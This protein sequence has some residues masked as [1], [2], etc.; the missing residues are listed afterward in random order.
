MIDLETRRW[1]ARISFPEPPDENGDD[2]AW[3]SWV[4]AFLERFIQAWFTLELHPNDDDTR[5]V[6]LAC[7]RKTAPPLLEAAQQAVLRVHEPW[8]F[9][10]PRTP[11]LIADNLL[12]LRSNI[13]YGNGET[14][15]L[16]RLRIHHRLLKQAIATA[17]EIDD[18]VEIAL[19]NS[20]AA[21]N[22]ALADA[23]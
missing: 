22:K 23:E 6:F 14:V 2:S 16:D 12:E 15:D 19:D 17:A 10:S 8:T 4:L 13:L 7:Q 9:S 3:H 18:Q 11:R 1:I 20:G 21:R 5:R